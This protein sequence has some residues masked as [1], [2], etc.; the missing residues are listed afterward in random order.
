MSETSEGALLQSKGSWLEEG[1]RKME[2]SAALL[3]DDLIFSVKL[4]MPP[5][6]Q[7]YPPQPDSVI[8]GRRQKHRKENATKRPQGAS[9]SKGIFIL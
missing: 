6:E 3:T 7:D 5:R 2:A 8:N 1:L 4:T 9:L